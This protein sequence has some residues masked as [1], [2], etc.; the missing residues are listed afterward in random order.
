MYVK[1]A[2]VTPALVGRAGD[3]LSIEASTQ[4][5]S[6]DES[7]TRYADIYF[8]LRLHGPKK[9]ESSELNGGVKASAG[10]DSGGDKTGAELSV[11][12][13]QATSISS[14]GSRPFRRAY[15]VTSLSK[16]TQ[17]GVFDWST[18]QL[19][20]KETNLRMTELTDARL[21]FSDFE[22][23]DDDVGDDLFSFYANWIIHSY[24]D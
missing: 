20:T 22:L 11:G 6:G 23:D 16:P 8:D 24:S 19:T 7:G 14:Q 12:G 18:H 13:K 17:Y 9:I 1:R 10:L 21:D 15:R 3:Y 4:P 2:T 5:L